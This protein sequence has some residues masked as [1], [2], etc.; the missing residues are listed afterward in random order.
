MNETGQPKPVRWDNPEGWGGE[1]AGRG[2]QDGETHVHQ[3]LIHVD[4]RQKPPEYCKA[5]VLQLK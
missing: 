3:W 5:I 1:V 4:V 2:I